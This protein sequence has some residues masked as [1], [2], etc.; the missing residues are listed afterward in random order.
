MIKHLPL[1]NLWPLPLCLA[2]AMGVAGCNKSPDTQARGMESAKMEVDS[3]DMKFFT[4]SAQDGMLEVKMAQMALQQA[5]KPEVRE[6]AQKLLDE[7]Q[8][9]NK[10]LLAL[11]TQ[12]NVSLPPALDSHAQSVVDDLKDEAGADFDKKYCEQLVDGHKDMVD[13]LDK[14]AK[15][16]ADTD[17]RAYAQRMLPAMQ[18][19]L[20]MAQGMSK[21]Q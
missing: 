7:H 8:S 15:D 12:K 19:H 1:Q 10:E 11:A 13:L 14:T 3:S 9:G 20:A 2:L 5:A 16:S 6:L 17:V 18:Q 21:A 4:D